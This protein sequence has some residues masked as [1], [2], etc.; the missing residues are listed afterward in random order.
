M[1][2]LNFESF[3]NYP[4]R[5]LYNYPLYM[6]PTIPKTFSSS[7][8]G[9]LC[10]NMAH[11]HIKMCVFAWENLPVKFTQCHSVL[12][13]FPTSFHSHLL[14][15]SHVVCRLD[16]KLY[17]YIC[18]HPANHVQLALISKLAHA[19]WCCGFLFFLLVHRPL[20]ADSGIWNVHKYNNTAHAVCSKMRKAWVML[21][22]TIRMLIMCGYGVPFFS[23]T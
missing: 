11:M 15:A 22:Y 5:T 20:L 8:N 14:T 21:V 3:Q 9:R 23:L 1:C 16:I 2:T 17:T 4:R 18:L 10:K 7:Y 12:P 6:S 19:C 13:V